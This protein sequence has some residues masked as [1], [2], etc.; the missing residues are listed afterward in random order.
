MTVTVDQIKNLRAKTGLGIHDVKKALEESNGD[1]TKAI[2]WLKEKGLSTVAKKS[3]RATSQGLIDVYTHNGRIGAMVEVNCETDFVA[4]NADFKA[5]VHD[6]ALQICSMD[7][8]NVEELLKQDFFKEP[9]KTIQ[10][11]LNDT[12]TKIGE[13]IKISRI[14]RFELGA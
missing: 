7:P 11:L 9:E 8:E 6:L 13:N 12:I 14:S 2:A 4:R 10:D 1:E 3:D 5:F